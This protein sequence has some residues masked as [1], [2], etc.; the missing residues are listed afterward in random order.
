MRLAIER[1]R[2]PIS[3]DGEAPR[4]KVKQSG[5]DQQL[6]SQS[7]RA[8]LGT[9]PPRKSTG[10]TTEIVGDAFFEVRY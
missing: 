6:T 10:V 4:E 5:V 2:I 3:A 7:P 1:Q 9:S 8:P